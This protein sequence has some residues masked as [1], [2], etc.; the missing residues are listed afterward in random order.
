M[1]RGT[2]VALRVGQPFMVTPEDDPI[3]RPPTYV[4]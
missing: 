3:K 2:L 4:R 1:T